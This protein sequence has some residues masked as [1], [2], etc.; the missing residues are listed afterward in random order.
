[1]SIAGRKIGEWLNPIVDEADK[2]VRTASEMKAIF[3]SNSNELKE[4]LNGLIDDVEAGEPVVTFRQAA[5]RANIAS[6]E[7]HKTIFGKIKKLFADLADVAFSA[8]Y[9]DLVDAPIPL[10]GASGQVL[11][12]R[13]SGTLDLEWADGSGAAAQVQPDL[14]DNNPNS[15]AYVRNR[16]IIAVDV[17][18]AASAFVLDADATCEAYP[19]KAVA[20]VQGVTA[21]MNRAEVTFYDDDRYLFAGIANLADGGVTVYANMIPLEAITIPTIVVW[22]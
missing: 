7:T 22:R 21:A 1:M 17:V 5:S 4:A 9:N 18:V 14:T 6:G 2:P 12:C 13:T 15:P 19:Y 8:S 10:D 11:R 16:P 20:A 3:D